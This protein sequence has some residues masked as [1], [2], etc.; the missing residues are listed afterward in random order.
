MAQRRTNWHGVFV[1]VVTP[2]TKNHEFDEKACRQII[3][4]LIKDGVHGIIVAGSTGEWFTMNDS[5]RIRLF[6]VAKD[7]VRGRVTLLGGTSAIATRD[8]VSLTKAAKNIGLD[9]VLLLPPPYVL[10]SER[11]ILA[12]FEAVSKVGLPIMIYNN[13]GRTQVNINGNLADK[14]SEFDTIVALKDS[15]KDLYQISETIRTVGDRLAIFC[16]LDPYT[17]ACIERGAVGVVAM[18]ANVIARQFVELYAHAISGRWPE[19]LKIQLLID[20]F[21]AS[22]WTSKYTGY[23]AIKESLNLMGRSGGWPRPPALPL[24]GSDKRELKRKLKDLG[25]L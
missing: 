14:L 15:I 12:A 17:L 22:I 4:I 8:A 2:F 16:G 9:G 21:H 10:P 11:E 3:D 19:A 20:Q 6:E 25:L 23:A 7:H 13:P 1:P 5:E 18:D 24:E